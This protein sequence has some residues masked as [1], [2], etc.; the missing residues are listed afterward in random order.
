MHPPNIHHVSRAGSPSG[1]QDSSTA[2][3]NL[4]TT[5][6]M[7][8]IAL[9]TK[10]RHHKPEHPCDCKYELSLLEEKLGGL[11]DHP[12]EL[13]ISEVERKQRRDAKDVSRLW[14]ELRE[15]QDRTDTLMTEHN[16]SSGVG[17][18]DGRTVKSTNAMY[19]VEQLIGRLREFEKFQQEQA[20]C[21]V[22]L[23]KR[24]D[25]MEDD[26]RRVQPWMISQIVERQENVADKIVRL[27]GDAKTLKGRVGELMTLKKIVSKQLDTIPDSA[28]SATK[29]GEKTIGDTAKPATLDAWITEDETEIRIPRDIRGQVFYQGGN[30]ER[31]MWVPPTSA[32]PIHT[33]YTHGV[34]MVLEQPEGWGN[35]RAEICRELEESQRIY[36]SSQPEPEAIQEKSE[37][38]DS[39]AGEEISLFQATEGVVPCQPDMLKKRKRRRRKRSKSI[40]PSFSVPN[41]EEQPEIKVEADTSQQVD[42][43]V[44]SETSVTNECLHSLDSY[45]STSPVSP[46]AA[47]IEHGCENEDTSPDKRYFELFA[48]SPAPKKSTKPLP[49]KSKSGSRVRARDKTRYIPMGGLFKQS[50]GSKSGK[51]SGKAVLNTGTIRGFE[52]LTLQ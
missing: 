33:P 41:E 34:P 32:E 18:S 12:W 28:D 2:S 50:K 35:V 17:K 9:E 16:W 49:R 3:Q 27:D 29:D 38:T 30:P 5:L 47:T 13:R 42:G 45:D 24:C 52:V 48:K 4:N 8:V 36:F 22:G 46:S 23:K 10:L 11:D 20:T 25:E 14:K 43:N 51:D 31:N 44:E 21:L 19:L 1:S 37:A 26:I 6:E 15:C 40:S 7:R 39:E